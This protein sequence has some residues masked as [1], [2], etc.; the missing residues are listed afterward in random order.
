MTSPH[1]FV[2]VRHGNTFA[3]GETPRRIGGRTDLCLTEQGRDQARSLGAHFAQAGMHFDRVLVSPLKRTI[4]T[5]ELIL[6]A[7]V[8]PGEPTIAEWLREV[9]HGPDENQPEEAVLARIGPDA[10]AAWE[11]RGEPPQGWRIDP[12]AQ[13]AAWHRLLTQDGSGTSLIVTSNGVAR[14]A[15]LCD[16]A[17]EEQATRLPT[18]KLPT[19]GYG[20]IDRTLE[21]H[22]VPL[23]LVAWG[24]RP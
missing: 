4:E 5:A 20:C 9:D 3:A 6:A 12:D 24:V 1:R 7:Q 11:R 22:R 14:F 19:G 23:Q 21:Q 2:V 17:L 18:L 16:R 13:R 8:G 15:L 10:L